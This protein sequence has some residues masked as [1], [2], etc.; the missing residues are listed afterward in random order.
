MYV[1]GKKEGHGVYMWS[2]G[3]LLTLLLDIYLYFRSKYEGEWHDNKISG[4]V[5]FSPK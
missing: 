1:N 2:D 3:Y 4:K 5:S